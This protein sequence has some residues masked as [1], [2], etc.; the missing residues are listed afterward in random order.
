MIDIIYITL[1]LFFLFISYKRTGKLVNPISLFTFFWCAIGL[2]SILET[3][4]MRIPSLTV[5]TYV[6]I[7]ISIVDIVILRFYLSK[8]LF[9]SAVHF[10]NKIVITLQIIATILYAYTF[11]SALAIFVLTEN[12]DAVRS[13]YYSTTTD[14]YIATLF[15]RIIPSGILDG[16]IIYYI[17][18][19]FVTGKFQF[20][21]YAA[22]DVILL[23]FPTGGRYAIMLIFFCIATCFLSNAYVTK[24]TKRQLF[25]CMLLLFIFVLYITTKRGQDVVYTL[26]TY[27]S[28][29]LSFLDYILEDP[30]SFGLNKYTYGYL[31]FG[32]IIEPIVLILKVLNLTSIK[33]PSFEFDQYCQQFYNISASSEALYFNNNTTILYHFIR[34]FGEVGIGI[35]ALF[36]SLVISI[37]MRRSNKSVFLNLV[38]IYFWVVLFESTFT[39]Q[40]FGSNVIFTFITLYLLSR[41]SYY[42]N[43]K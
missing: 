16:L 4:G 29:S 18:R 6:W 5:H 38:Y 27:F 42:V 8:S 23:T 13:M 32:A 43:I 12:F 41:K 31:T 15:F 35:G 14:N 7:F 30:R 3:Q 20:V 9:S 10:D 24:K 2:L 40:F 17:F 39:Y 28:G 21:V 37:S 33:T 34:D 19:L 11:F 1:F 25:F 26:Q 36:I 22:L